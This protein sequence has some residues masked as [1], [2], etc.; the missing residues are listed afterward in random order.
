MCESRLVFIALP[1]TT[2]N[3]DDDNDDNDDDDDDDDDDEN[4]GGR[5]R[6]MS[7]R[8]SCLPFFPF[9]P[10]GQTAALLNQ[11]QYHQYRVRKGLVPG[12]P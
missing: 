5:Q 7:E 12:I 10:F 8:A 11:L 2:T 3:D 4:G 9:S 6:R 1:P